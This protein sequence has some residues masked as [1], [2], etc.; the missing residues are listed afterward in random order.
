MQG[1]K[2]LATKSA[3]DAIEETDARLSDAFTVI[4]YLRLGMHIR[5]FFYYLIA[6]SPL[7]PNPYSQSLNNV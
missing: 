6:F 2:R 4:G 3:I 7:T 5:S 1:G